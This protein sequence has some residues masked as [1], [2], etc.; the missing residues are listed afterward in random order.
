MIRAAQV[1]ELGSGALLKL[2]SYWLS[3][4]QGRAMPSRADIDPSEIKDL[5]PHILMARLEYDPLRV[6]YTIV[7]TA[8]ARASAFD[9]TGL[10][11]DQL[12]FG[13]EIDTDWEAIYVE[14]ARDK[15]PVIGTCTFRTA[16]LDRTYPVAV[17]PLSND[18][19]RVDHTIAYEDLNLTLMDIDNVLPVKPVA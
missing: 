16:Y 9:Y 11:L 8:S 10:Y 13:S 4:R 18:G 19:I 1:T 2:E 12:R 14:I 6:K 15:Q 17:F 3:K 5:L 7:G